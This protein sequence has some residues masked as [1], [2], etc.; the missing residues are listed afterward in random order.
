MKGSA[1]FTF[2]VTLVVAVG[3]VLHYVQ[4]EDKG[5]EENLFVL[6]KDLSNI[7]MKDCVSCHDVL[8]E[9]SLDRNIR[10]AHVIHAFFG[11]EG[12]LFCHQDSDIN[13]DSGDLLR[14]HVDMKICLECHVSTE[15][16][17]KASMSPEQE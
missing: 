5:A 11:E 2:F 13:Q 17:W 12:C 7:A 8:N 3:F 9:R 4:A 14:K 15:R 16:E 6:H 1:K 10:T